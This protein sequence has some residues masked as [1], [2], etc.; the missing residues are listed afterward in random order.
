MP[1]TAKALK[2][3]LPGHPGEKI[4]LLRRRLGIGQDQLAQDAGVHL[5][6]V[7][8]IEQGKPYTSPTLEAL[9]KALK[10]T[11]SVLTNPLVVD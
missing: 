6:T 5:N 3:M 7:S 4:L 1:K 8:A 9:A 10:T 2:P 11:V